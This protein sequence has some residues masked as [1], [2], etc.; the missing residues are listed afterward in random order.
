MLN[1]TDNQLSANHLYRMAVIKETNYNYWQGFR[2]KKSLYT[3]VWSVNRY[4]CFRTYIQRNETPRLFTRKQH[5]FV[6]AM[7]QRINI[8]RLSPQ[9]SGAS[10]YI[11]Q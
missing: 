8:Q 4:I 9:H 5:L 3:V 6:L 10:P 7:A 1:T 2:K 11:L